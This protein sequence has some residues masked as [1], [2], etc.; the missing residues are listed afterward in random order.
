MKTLRCACAGVL[1]WR[2]DLLMVHVKTLLESCKGKGQYLPTEHRHLFALRL[3]EELGFPSPR[4]V[5]LVEPE[6]N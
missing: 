4:R 2:D 3:L 1:V 6:L 5:L